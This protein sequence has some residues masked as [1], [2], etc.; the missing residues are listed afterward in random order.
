MSYRLK[1]W[2]GIK[3]GLAVTATP[4]RVAKELMLVYHFRILSFLGVN[5][6][7]KKE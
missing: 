7:I 4:L 6:N 3:Y 5:K 2:P 1:L